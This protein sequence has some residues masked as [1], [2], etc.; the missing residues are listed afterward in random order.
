MHYIDIKLYSLPLLSSLT[1]HVSLYSFHFHEDRRREAEGEELTRRGV[2]NNGTMF[3]GIDQR[4]NQPKARDLSDRR[5]NRSK[6]R[7]S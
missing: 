7:R 2:D 3:V 5:A 6:A 4:S 1:G